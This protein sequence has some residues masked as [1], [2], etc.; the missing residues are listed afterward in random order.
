MV[1]GGTAIRIDDKTKQVVDSLK[2]NLQNIEKKS[3][4]H[5]EILRRTFSQNS[6][7]ADI[8]IEDSINHKS[9]SKR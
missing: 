6:P 1:K 2:F 8:L 4:S 7:I 3:I 9:R 5:Q